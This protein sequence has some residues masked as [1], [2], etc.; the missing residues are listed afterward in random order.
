MSI[1]I[2]ERDYLFCK[3]YIVCCLFTLIRA[4]LVNFLLWITKLR[5]AS[6]S[7]QKDREFVLEKLDQCKPQLSSYVMLFDVH[8]AVMIKNMLTLVGTCSVS[9]PLSK[10]MA[11]TFRYK[12]CQMTK[13]DCSR[14]YDFPVPSFCLLMEAKTPFG[15]GFGKYVTPK[16]TCPVKTGH[17]RVNLTISLKSIVDIPAS[18]I[19]YRI[20]YLFLDAFKKDSVGCVELA[21][22]LRQLP[23]KVKSG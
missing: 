16:F 14:E 11:V 2:K 19:R 3:A 17:Y 12:R 21:I 13:D 22:W 23:Q 15:D 8:K 18:R 6:K 5:S 10:S 9:E 7:L 1:K 4:G 20:K